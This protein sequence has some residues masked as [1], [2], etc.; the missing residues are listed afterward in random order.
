MSEAIA[1]V[2][3]LVVVGLFGWVVWSAEAH[4]Q[5]GIECGAR[6]GMYLED[7]CV[8]GERIDLTKAD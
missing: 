3:F 1:A 5:A 2:A 6:G 4:R 7:V 8:K